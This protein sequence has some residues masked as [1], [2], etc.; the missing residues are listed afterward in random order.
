MQGTSLHPTGPAL[1]AAAALLSTAYSS[2]YSRV[3]DP[4]TIVTISRYTKM[5]G[6]RFEG[7]LIASIFSAE[8]LRALR[9]AIRRYA[10]V[11]LDM[12]FVSGFGRIPAQE[13]NSA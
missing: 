11:A 12:G 5:A 9:V 6:D 13:D 4:W 3:E 2:C 1:A 8:K 7:S 10:K